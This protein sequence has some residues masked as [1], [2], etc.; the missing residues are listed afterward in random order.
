[1]HW[2]VHGQVQRHYRIATSHI[3]E[4]MHVVTTQGQ[5]GVLVPVEAVAS[6]CDGVAVVGVVH[7]QM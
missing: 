7:G 4:R 3:A 5:V 1:M 2:I 6:H